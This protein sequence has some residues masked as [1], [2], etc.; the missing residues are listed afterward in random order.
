MSAGTATINDGR[1]SH[2][3]QLATLAALDQAY[4]L[5]KDSTHSQYKNR[6]PSWTSDDG[7]FTTQAMPLNVTDEFVTL[8]NNTGKSIEVPLNR[9]DEKSIEFALQIRKAMKEVENKR[10]D[11]V[12]SPFAELESKAS[13]FEYGDFSLS[14]TDIADSNMSYWLNTKSNTRHNSGCRFFGNTSG[15]RECSA[16]EGKACGI[17]GG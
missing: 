16:D 5:E 4:A 14:Q 11:K 6:Y 2:T 8:R 15:G 3:I 10:S 13:P 9:L 12:S 7:A 17:C 1:D